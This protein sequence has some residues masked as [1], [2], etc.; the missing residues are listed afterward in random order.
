M[1]NKY[2]LMITNVDELDLEYGKCFNYMFNTL[3][4]RAKKINEIKEV[5]RKLPETEEEYKIDGG[6][7]KYEYKYR[8]E[9]AQKKKVVKRRGA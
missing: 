3:K 2:Y 1:E 8:W 5:P 6:Y 9:I 4:E 7:E